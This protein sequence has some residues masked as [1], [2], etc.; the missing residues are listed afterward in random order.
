M[1]M[2]I[3]RYPSVRTVSLVAL[4]LLIANVAIAQPSPTSPSPK[5]PTA[6]GPTPQASYQP[7]PADQLDEI[8]RRLEN[9]KLEA[10][11]AKIKSDMS[12]DTRVLENQKLKAE[13]EKLTFDTSQANRFA[14]WIA[15]LVSI[16][17]IVVLVAG[18]L[19]TRK[20]AL[21]VQKEQGNQALQLKITELIMASRSP[22][23]AGMRGELL[24]TLYEKNGTNTFFSKI[25]EMTAKKQF[26]GDLGH[27][28]RIKVF[29]ELAAKYENPA[30]V[31]LLAENIFSG[32][33]WLKQDIA[34]PKMLLPQAPD[35]SPGSVVS[36]T[37]S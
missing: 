13:I 26:P 5:T 19:N 27:E 28:V 25:K 14:G 32:D 37:S 33:E 36:S 8:K 7:P 22:A 16:L 30:D 4:A 6:T 23:L 15:P 2:P 1:E 34:P 21:N 9:E 17:T 18:L 24:S 29:E 31:K 35:P 3:V 20:T 11:I 10:E 12:D